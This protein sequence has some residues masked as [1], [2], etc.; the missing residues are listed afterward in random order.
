MLAFLLF[1]HQL[2]KLVLLVFHVLV[3]VQILTNLQRNLRILH[4]KQ[5]VQ[6]QE[7]AHYYFHLENNFQFN[8]PFENVRWLPKPWQ[9]LADVAL[10]TGH[11]VMERHISCG[12]QRTIFEHN[13]GIPWVTEVRQFQ[14]QPN[15]LPVGLLALL[16]HYLRRGRHR[17][18]HPHHHFGL[19]DF[20]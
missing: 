4:W 16:V 13:E 10:V 6:V 7:A 9:N 12:S 14:R 5:N 11:V 17:R 8:R 3:L 19:G 2:V 1:F 20:Y 18:L 15:S